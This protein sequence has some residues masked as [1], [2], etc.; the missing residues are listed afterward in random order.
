MILHTNDTHSNIDVA[1][2]GTGGVL[3]RKAI[4]DS[5]RNAEKNVVLVDAGDMVQGTLYFN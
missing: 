3:P 4:I 5:V 2:D 1:P